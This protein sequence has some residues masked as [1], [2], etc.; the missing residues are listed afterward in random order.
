MEIGKTIAC[1]V[2]EF[3]CGQQ[4]AFWATDT[5]AIGILGT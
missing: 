4:V 5:M 3:S 2:E 1:M